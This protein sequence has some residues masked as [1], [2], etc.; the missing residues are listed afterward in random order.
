MDLEDTD[1]MDPGAAVEAIEEHLQV[2][3]SPRLGAIRNHRLFTPMEEDPREWLERDDDD[4]DNAGAYEE[5]YKYDAM[6]IE[7]SAKKTPAVI[8][9][10]N[11]PI[12]SNSSG[13]RSTDKKKPPQTPEVPFNVQSPFVSSN[14][15]N[16]ATT[17]V[18]SIRTERRQ[19]QASSSSSPATPAIVRRSNPSSASDHADYRQHQML[20]E[21]YVLGK[22][23]VVDQYSNL[24]QQNRIDHEENASAA[25]ASLSAILPASSHTAEQTR[26][27]G[28]EERRNELE[29][30][31]G[32][33]RH[34]W[35]RG[36]LAE[37]NFWK[38]L[39]T[40]RRVG[41]AALIWN[42]DEASTQQ[43]S[44][45]ITNFLQRL[46]RDNVQLT[47]KALIREMYSHEN[48]P[49][50]LQRRKSVLH[51][52]E[53]CF[54]HVLA[55][56]A[57]R[58]IHK[59]NPILPSGSSSSQLNE[60]GGFYET[61]L[62]AELFRKSLAL[63][64]AGRLQDALQLA[65]DSGVAFR[66]AQ[67]SGGEP[68][69][70][71][72]TQG[73]D[74]I[75][76][77]TGNQMR[78]LWR[79]MAW[80]RA[81]SMANHG[82]NSDNNSQKAAESDEMAIMALLSSNVVVALDSASL[83][84]WEKGLYVVTKCPLDRLEDQLLHWHNNHRRECT[85]PY[86][87]TKYEKYECNHL[88]LTSGI[89]DLNEAKA[90]AVLET[91]PFEE[92][93]R[94]D[95]VRDATA[96]FLAGR[97][98]L[99]KL[100]STTTSMLTEQQMSQYSSDELRFLTHLALYLDS[101]ARP[102]EQTSASPILLPTMIGDWKD[103]LLLAYVRLL[104]D[105]QDLWYLVVFYATLLPTGTL[106]EELPRLLVAIESPEERITIEKQLREHLPASIARE[107]LG[108]TVHAALA[109]VTD[110]DEDGEDDGDYRKMR[111]VLWL[112]INE[113]HAL[114]ALV[115]ANTLLRQF[116]L[117]NKIAS[118]YTFLEDVFDRD[119][120][121][122]LDGIDR[123]DLD[124][125]QAV[126]IANA[127]GE[128]AA[129]VAFHERI[130]AVEIWE[131]KWAQIDAIIPESVYVDS[132]IDKSQCNG[133]ETAAVITL[134]RRKLIDAKRKAFQAIVAAADVAEQKVRQVL[135][136]PT[137]WLMT[138][139]EM[140]AGAAE[141]EQ[142]RHREL[143]QLRRT[144]LPDTVLLYHD[145]CFE[146]ALWLSKALDDAVE[147][148]GDE[149]QIVPM[150]FLEKH[151][152]PSAD[153]KE[154]PMAPRYWTQKALQVAELTQSDEYGIHKAFSTANHKDLMNKLVETRVADL[155][156]STLDAYLRKQGH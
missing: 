59:A 119:I 58:A 109:E 130:Q 21:A 143:D 101:L 105:R 78:A 61:D 112:R 10:A 28:L 150:A 34:A 124:E 53:M 74:G 140:V 139:D 41:L 153:D 39:W 136:H 36:R 135:E 22:R 148:F 154:S 51:W 42:D 131:T 152:D 55:A 118:A 144:M 83:R 128:H 15:P 17:A 84:S 20:M 114:D 75:S 47:P 132:S 76:K 146:T 43:N 82:G 6:E 56:D 30:L 12:M 2:L 81:E 7:E 108:R 107:V 156:F 49:L 37:G 117:A 85:P 155:K 122:T 3:V 72:E 106:L 24:Q 16:A 60:Q 57:T 86:P 14:A 142:R 129:F 18:R 8:H 137:G 80:K 26:Q 5:E 120:L 127:Q 87:G 123:D 66:A 133:I 54:H 70:Y 52:L 99:E 104:A 96:A 125:I 147:K 151:L 13:T 91:S 9:R 29:L 33:N 64:L 94:K 27:L 97:S 25:A 4:D 1:P 115:A 65:S 63:M 68:Q 77:E 126:Q 71:E 111:A 121:E 48:I 100:V 44:D 103:I 92:M 67:W 19:K 89:S 69:G 93:Q 62:D 23:H 138:D 79:H 11:T 98:G 35:S 149:H 50:P 73:T 95:L 110:D 40:L 134:E 102:S 46:A 38:L 32:L 145:I 90:V 88:S 113:D 45:S 116:Y 31:S 141:S